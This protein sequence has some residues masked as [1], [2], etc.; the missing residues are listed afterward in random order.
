MASFVSGTEGAVYITPSVDVERRLLL[1]RHEFDSVCHYD[2]SGSSP[3]RKLNIFARRHSKRTQQVPFSA[4]GLLVNPYGCR[5]AVVVYD[6][7]R[8]SGS[9]AARRPPRIDIVVAGLQSRRPFRRFADR[10][11]AAIAIV[12]AVFIGGG[13]AC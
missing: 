4:I 12:R 6:V 11:G 7:R 13:S 2:I 8:C 9:V 1:F 3:A 10:C 5:A